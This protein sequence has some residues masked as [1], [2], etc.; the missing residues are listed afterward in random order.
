MSWG[1]SYCEAHDT[2][3]PQMPVK[4][5][6]LFSEQIQLSTAEVRF[7]GALARIDHCA[8]IGQGSDPHPNRIVA[9]FDPNALDLSQLLNMQAESGED[10][11]RLD[12]EFSVADLHGNAVTGFGHSS[13]EPEFDGHLLIGLEPP[14]TPSV[15]TEGLITLYRTPWGSE[16]APLNS[17]RV[18]GLAGAA[19][20]NGRGLV[21]VR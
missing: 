20:P 9:W 16:S 2:Q 3:I 7:G 15:D 1:A 18:T 13:S 4:I 14:E 5:S 8:S 11:V 12:L 6:L 17:A 10:S 21:G 19:T